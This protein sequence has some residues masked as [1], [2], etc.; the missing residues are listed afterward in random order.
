[1]L[2]VCWMIIN[3]V[4]S[5]KP[6]GISVDLTIS[7]PE[8]GR[9]S[10]SRG[11]QSQH[12]RLQTPHHALKQRNASQVQLAVTPTAGQS[13]L[14]ACDGL[15][16]RPLRVRIEPLELFLFT[17]L[18]SPDVIL[19]MHVLPPIFLHN[20]TPPLEY[21]LQQGRAVFCLLLHQCLE[22]SRH[23]MNTHD[24]QMLA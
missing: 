12:C 17:H 24:Q 4:L 15:T 6:T 5:W 16:M 19:Y 18:P 22:H 7:S 13:V 8:T 1:M 23:L 14:F 3:I 10:L 2:A 9:R 20:L 21:Q 11:L